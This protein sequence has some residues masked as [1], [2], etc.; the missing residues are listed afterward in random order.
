MSFTDEQIRLRDRVMPGY[1]EPE[2]TFFEV[3]DGVEDPR[4]IIYDARAG[5]RK[6]KP[7]YIA[8]WALNEER[9][10]LTL[11]STAGMLLPTKGRHKLGDIMDTLKT[12]EFNQPEHEIIAF[13]SIPRFNG[14]VFE[15]TEFYLICPERTRVDRSPGIDL[16]EGDEVEIFDGSGKKPLGTGVYL[17]TATVYAVRTPKGLV[18]MPNAEDRPDASMVP[19]GCS[20]AT[21]ENNPKFRLQDGRIVYGCQVW[22]ALKRRPTE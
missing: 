12:V 2:T 3:P 6:N 5:Q 20:V 8:V 21:I 7:V 17:G 11:T 10:P 13:C 15:T 18:S 9:R 14:Y 16:K 1:G 22:W 4:E 19:P